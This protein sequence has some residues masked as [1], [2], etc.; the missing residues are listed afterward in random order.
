MQTTAQVSDVNLIRH[1]RNR[2]HRT[3]SLASQPVSTKGGTQQSY[4][5]MKK[6]DP[7]KRKGVLRHQTNHQDSDTRILIQ[8]RRDQNT[9]SIVI[10]M[11]IPI[12]GNMRLSNGNFDRRLAA[13]STTLQLLDGT[14][15][16]RTTLI[17]NG[18]VWTQQEHN[19]AFRQC[20]AWG[21]W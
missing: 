7:Q 6:P 14:T 20:Q 19:L 16:Q 8:D 12:V 3:Q 1:T 18:A 21:G 2:A 5:A 9:I 10:T 17:Q 13:P 4:D 11:P 15:R